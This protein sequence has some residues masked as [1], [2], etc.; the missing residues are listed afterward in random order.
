MTK[1]SATAKIILF[2][3]NEV[4]FRIIDEFCKWRPDSFLARRLSEFHQYETYA[5]DRTS[6][7][8]WKTWPTVHRGIHDERHMIQDFGQ[9]L[10]E[11]NREFPPLWEILAANGV[12]TAVCGS[13]HS[14]PMPKSMENYAFY[15]PDTFAAGSE[16]FP[17]TLSDFQAFNLQMTRASAL[18][19]SRKLPWESTLRFL[20]H[21]RKLGV[22]LG[23]FTELGKQLLAERRQSS[24]KVRRRTYQAELAF[25]IF[26]NFLESTKPAFATFFTN[27]VASSMHRFWAAAFPDDY[28][29]EDFA[30]DAAWIQT[31]RGE[32]DF[33]MRK[34]DSYLARL[35]D[36]VDHNGEYKLW[37][38]SSMGQAATRAQ[39]VANELNLKDVG[40]FM[41]AL[42]FQ[43]PNWS[44]RPAMAPQC[45]LVVAPGCIE[46][47]RQTLRGISVYGKPLGYRESM[48]GFFSLDFGH[49]GQPELD[50][51]VTLGN[52]R[53]SFAEMGLE[54]REIEDRSNANAYHIPQGTLLIY[55]PSDRRRREARPQVSTLEIAPTILKNFQ[56]PVPSYMVQPASF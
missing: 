17:K 36:F 51:C 6:L 8:P 20:A 29:P 24:L 45:N 5:A 31:Y 30:V 50:Q 44:L 23:T 40:K 3:L 47:F 53:L 14:Y 33:A 42:G 52:R 12:S 7:S 27:H 37:I 18:N 2:E 39:L 10:R 13:M 46:L 11:V 54:N 25:D 28:Q 1:S 41:S 16:C 38:A 32:I 19:V 9:D 48:N 35:A 26:I 55:D 22:R 4:P 43:T 21:A 56:L 49:P 34:F 15:L